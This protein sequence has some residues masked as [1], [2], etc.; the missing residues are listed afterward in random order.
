MNNHSESRQE[1]REKRAKKKKEQL[2]KHGK[3]LG[4]IY[5]DAVSK[6]QKEAKEEK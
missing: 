2:P 3:T 1:K 5:K 4:K 6:R